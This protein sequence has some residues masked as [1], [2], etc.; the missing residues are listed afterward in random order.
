MPRDGAVPNRFFSMPL[1]LALAGFFQTRSPSGVLQLIELSSFSHPYQN[2]R[3]SV[4]S[5]KG[6]GERRKTARSEPRGRRPWFGQFAGNG[7][8]LRHS[9]RQAGAEKECPDWVFWRSEGDSNCGYD[10]ARRRARAG[11]MVLAHHRQVIAP[12]ALVE[13]RR[14]GRGCSR[15]DARRGLLP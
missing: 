2:G 6:A 12:P 15:P 7:R 10:R 14:S 4:A 13:L 3:G 1:P 8:I 9:R 11:P 5:E